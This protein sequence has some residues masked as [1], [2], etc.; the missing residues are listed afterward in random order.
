MTTKNKSDFKKLVAK[1]KTL[2][3]KSHDKAMGSINK[4]G[5]DLTNNAKNFNLQKEE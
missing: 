3:R 5:R 1:H 2:L 4:L